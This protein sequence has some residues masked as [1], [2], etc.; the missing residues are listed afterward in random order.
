MSVQALT[1]YTL[2]AKG[3]QGLKLP[4]SKYTQIS[5]GFRFIVP[6]RSFKSR[7]LR[8]Y[9]H[10]CLKCKISNILVVYGNIKPMGKNIFQIHKY[11]LNTC[12]FVCRC[13]SLGKCKE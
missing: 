5:I 8:R 13:T 3:K 7:V 2:P 12:I 4:L 1:F 6:K 11:C 9:C 10:S